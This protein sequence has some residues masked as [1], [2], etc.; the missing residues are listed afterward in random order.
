M[1]DQYY[2]FPDQLHIDAKLERAY[3]EDYLLNATGDHAVSLR[4]REAKWR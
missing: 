3:R 2:D 4:S 1:N